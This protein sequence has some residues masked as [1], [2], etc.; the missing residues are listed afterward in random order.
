MQAQA[1]E[2]FTADETVLSDLVGASQSAVGALQA[3]QATNQILA[4]QA[5]Q[6]MQGQQLQIAQDRAVALEHARAVAAE[7]RS[8]ELRRRFMSAETTYTAEPITPFHE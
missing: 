5:R 7:E 1:T 8:R 4:L 2:N 3:S 6:L